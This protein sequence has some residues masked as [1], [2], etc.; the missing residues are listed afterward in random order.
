MILI[1][2]PSNDVA[3]QFKDLIEE[4]I[5]VIKIIFNLSFKNSSKK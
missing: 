5:Q 3:L 2:E 1:Y 4:K